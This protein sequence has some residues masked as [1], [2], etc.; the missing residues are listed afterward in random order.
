M[1]NRTWRQIR[2]LLTAATLWPVSC[3]ADDMLPQNQE[4]AAS[5]IGYTQA[6]EKECPGLKAD[7][8]LVGAALASLSVS[9]AD[10]AKMSFANV[11]QAYS[12]KYEDET[13]CNWVFV[14]H[15]PSGFENRLL[16]LDGGP[17]GAEFSQRFRRATEQAARDSADIAIGRGACQLVVDEQS[18]DKYLLLEGLDERLL[19]R[20]A[21]APAER[22][23]ADFRREEKAMNDRIVEIDRGHADRREWCQELWDEFGEHGFKSSNVLLKPAQPYS[24]YSLK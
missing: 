22:S 21:R 7:Q 24:P 15:G 16:K 17:E 6:V 8:K 18:L 9:A 10:R 12:D 2:V 1:D 14:A 20:G 3:Y 4:T 5:I 11:V 19:S 13:H 23:V